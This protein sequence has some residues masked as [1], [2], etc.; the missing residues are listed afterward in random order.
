[1]A[2]ELLERAAMFAKNLLIVIAFSLAVLA[3]LIM[4]MSVI[5]PDV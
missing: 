3:L 2:N 5:A 1:M 4:K